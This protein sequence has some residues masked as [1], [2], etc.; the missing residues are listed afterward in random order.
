MY[1]CFAADF[2]CPGCGTVSSAAAYTNMQTHLR[3]DSDGSTL[4][5][6]YEFEP[7]DLTN[8]HI[9]GAG[10][11]RISPPSEGGAI[12]LLDVWSCP[13]CETE[14]WAMVEIADRKIARIEAVSMSRATFEVANFISEVDAELLA[15]SLLGISWAELSARNLNSVEV[16]KQQ[17]T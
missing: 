14:Q 12:R 8:K 13:A 15:V 9:V 11:S 1:D 3:G 4:A 6:G 16:L 7:V 17:L 2:R 5:V 10:Y